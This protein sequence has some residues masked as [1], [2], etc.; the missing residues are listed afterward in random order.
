MLAI[1]PATNTITVGPR[2][3]LAVRMISAVRPTWTGRPLDDGW[4]GH[5]Q[6]RAHGRPMEAS[7]AVRDQHLEVALDSAIRAVA[8]GQAVVLYE[9]SRVVGSAT[10][11][12]TQA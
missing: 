7:V 11:S 9:G 10:I 4:S 8:P 5:V 3:A 1:T 6:V 12:A 2:D